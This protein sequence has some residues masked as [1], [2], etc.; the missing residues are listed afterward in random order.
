MTEEDIKII[1][2]F[3]AAND[4]VITAKHAVASA[5]REHKEAIKEAFAADVAYRDLV[6]KRQ[7]LQDA[8]L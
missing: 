6:K 2:N 8:A 7:E 5:K 1:D 3:I 4:L